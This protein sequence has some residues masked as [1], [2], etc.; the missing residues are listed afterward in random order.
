MTLLL[1]L[2]H[3]GRTLGRAYFAVQAVA[4]AL[5]WVGVFTLPQVREATLGGLDPVLT[6]ALDIPLFVVASGVAATAF[7]PAVWVATVWTACV[8]VAMMLYATITQEAGWGALAMMAAAAGSVA[9]ALLI[10]TGRLPTELVLFG[11]FA[12]HLARPASAARNAARTGLQIVVFWGLALGVVPV[13]I[14]TVEQRW[15]VSLVLPEG[16]ANG[17]RIAG[18]ALFLAAS[19]LGLWSAASMS[20]KGEGTPLP[21]AMPRA[22]VVSGPYRLVR[23]PMAV[24]GISQGVAVGLMMNSWLVVVYALSGSLV[25]NW[26]IRPLEEAD[27]AE[28]FGPA[29]EEYRAR[30]ACWIPRR[31]ARNN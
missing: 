10:Q 6:A 13:I 5:W 29:F 26:V 19:A 12:F 1:A 9:A 27:L 31:P 14:A 16:W 15:K 30:V 22:L 21:S 3:R 2:K 7:R 20:T 28:R 4:G 23:N 18:V 25:W 17:V 24:A 11:P 8:T